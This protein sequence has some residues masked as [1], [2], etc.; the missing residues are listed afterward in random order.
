MYEFSVFFEWFTR[1]GLIGYAIF[2]V[3]CLFKNM[4]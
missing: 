2:G 4:K 3:Y 1:I